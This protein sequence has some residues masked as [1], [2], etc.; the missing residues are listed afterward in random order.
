MSSENKTPNLQLNQWTGNE[1]PKRTD[2][3]EDNRKIDE[4]YKELKDSIKDG[5][6]VSSVNG[7]I[8]DVILKAEDIKTESG[9]TVQSQMADMVQ[10]MVQQRRTYAELKEMAEDSKLSVGHFYILEDYKCTYLRS[11][12]GSSSADKYE[13]VTSP[14]A[15]KLILQA[16]TKNTFSI[17]C[18]SVDYPDDILVFDIFDDDIK[19]DLNNDK[20][21][22]TPRTGKVH[23]RYDTKNNIYTNY[24]FRA[25]TV[26]VFRQDIKRYATTGGTIL[27]TNERV[28]AGTVVRGSF[29]HNGQSLF[30]ALATT[31]VNT[32]EGHANVCKICDRAIDVLNVESNTIYMYSNKGNELTDG[33]LVTSISPRVEL[34]IGNNCK[35]IYV[36]TGYQKHIHTI[37]IGDNC[38]NIELK[39]SRYIC[40]GNDC[41]RINIFDSLWVATGDKTVTTRI[42]QSSWVALFGNNS[43]IYLNSCS[44]VS[45]GYS[46]WNVQSTSTSNLCTGGQNKSGLTTSY[47]YNSNVFNCSYVD[48]SKN[49]SNNTITASDT[50][51]IDKNSNTNDIRNSTHISIDMGCN[52]NYMYNAKYISIGKD[53][54][55]N[56]FPTDNHTITLGIGCK[57]NDFGIFTH[58]LNVIRSNSSKY[59][60]DN[61]YMIVL[62]LRNKDITKFTGGMTNYSTTKWVTEGD[63]GNNYYLC[64]LT[65]GGSYTAKLIP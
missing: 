52:C 45:I 62:N 5:G 25:V 17:Y 11:K 12:D 29:Y 8:G 38:T 3:I 54:S 49:S 43:K 4:A 41:S 18:K 14:K 56:R 21:P 33:Y 10:H 24:D 59:S 28:S 19:N 47:D 60:V 20:I 37:R 63:S 26:L 58:D 2:F 42:T 13:V 48:I 23:S 36:H 32:L 34:T 30:V 57:F 64:Y 39:D 7:K 53:C 50:V 6:K 61:S 9:D 16:I 55:D 46:F 15:E 22:N 51:N 35:D 44:K 27:N 65:G 40:I 1:Y 31:T